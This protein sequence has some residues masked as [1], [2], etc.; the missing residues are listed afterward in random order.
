MPPDDAIA[1]SGQI[2]LSDIYDEF[3]G[4]HSSQEIQLSDY[5]DKGNAPASGEIQLATDF[6]G[7]SNV[8]AWLGD[9][10]IGTSYIRQSNSSMSGTCYTNNIHYRSI[11]STSLT[12]DFGSFASSSIIGVQDHSGVQG[13]G[14][15]MFQGGRQSTDGSSWTTR[16]PMMWYIT[17]AST[18]NA[19]VGNSMP[20]HSQGGSTWDGFKFQ[21]NGG[22]SNGTTGLICPTERTNTG[23]STYI[24]PTMFYNTISSTSSASVGGSLQ[25]NRY[26]SGAGGPTYA[27][28]IGGWNGSTRTDTIEYQAYSSPGN[29]AGDWGNLTF[30]AQSYQTCD[31]DSRTITWGGYGNGTSGSLSL[32]YNAMNYWNNTSTGNASA[33]GNTAPVTCNSSYYGK[34]SGMAVSNGTRGEKWAGMGYTGWQG[35]GGCNY[36]GNLNIDYVTIASTG[37]AADSGYNFSDLDSSGMTY[38]EHDGCGISGN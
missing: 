1:G 17:V 13:G 34:Y 36:I 37:N 38:T 5:H 6:Y 10:G 4:T 20:S 14:R 21:N 30:G 3:T 11:S 8:P 26:H 24:N 9:R 27:F 33:F 2:K 31:S 25:E 15:G 32:Y 28:W 29:N 22:G 23:N 7:T 35:D 12:A 18:G 16:S 19:S